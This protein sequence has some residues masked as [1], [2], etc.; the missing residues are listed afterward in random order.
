MVEGPAPIP[1]ELYLSLGLRSNH[2]HPYYLM[3]AE[4]IK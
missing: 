1:E 3:V 4:N 2:C